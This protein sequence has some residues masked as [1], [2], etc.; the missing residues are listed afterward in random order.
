MSTAPPQ[1]VKSR[2]CDTSA[3]VEVAEV[4]D[5]VAIRN[6][7]EPDASFTVG[8][9]VQWRRFLEGVKDGEFA[10]IKPWTGS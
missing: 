1:W 7:T 5:E 10:H 9:K 3:C 6:S 4:E 8:S 2:R